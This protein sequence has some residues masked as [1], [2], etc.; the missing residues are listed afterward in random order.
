[1]ILLKMILLECRGVS[2]KVK[3]LEGESTDQN[4]SK[5]RKISY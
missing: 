4:K 1:M 5:N 2:V 3:I